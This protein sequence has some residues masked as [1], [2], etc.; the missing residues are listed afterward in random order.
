[1][2]KVD[3]KAGAAKKVW[4]IFKGKVEPLEVVAHAPGKYGRNNF[5]LVRHV[6]PAHVRAIVELDAEQL[7]PSEKAALRA[8]LRRAE[9][10]ASLA[11]KQARRSRAYHAQEIRSALKAARLAAKALARAEARK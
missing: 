9:A 6:G 10:K 2:A 8:L 11:E 3:K 1:M 7:F 5:R 4:A